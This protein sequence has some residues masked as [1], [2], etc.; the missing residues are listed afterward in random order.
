MHPGALV[1]PSLST[2]ILPSLVSEFSTSRP[3]C[4]Q[5][6]HFPARGLCSKACLLSS[7]LCWSKYTAPHL[8]STPSGASPQGPSLTV[9]T[10]LLWAPSLGSSGPSGRSFLSALHR[11]R[12]SDWFRGP[13]SGQGGVGRAPGVPT[14]LEGA[15]GRP[16]GPGGR[17]QVRGTGA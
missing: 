11:V 2:A 14:Q 15:A 16:R 4:S 8:G 5:P 7:P 3:P 17:G 9:L 10:S 1:P 13:S 6:A 12:G